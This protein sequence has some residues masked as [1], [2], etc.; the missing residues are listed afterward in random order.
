[1]ESIFALSIILIG[2]VFLAAFFVFVIIPIIWVGSW[3]YNT[4]FR[5]HIYSDDD[6]PL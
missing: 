2:I 5:Q 6:L 1:M 3:I 4:Y